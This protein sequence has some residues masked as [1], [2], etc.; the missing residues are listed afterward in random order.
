[1]SNLATLEVAE[2]ARDVELSLYEGA[3]CCEGPD[4]PKTLL[5][6]VRCLFK[7]ECVRSLGMLLAFSN[8]LRQ[9]T[10]LHSGSGGT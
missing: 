8:S 1:M 10:Q 2:L 5:A 4:A 9:R 7:P 3:Q 6:L